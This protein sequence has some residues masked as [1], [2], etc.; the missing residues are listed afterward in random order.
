MADIN[1]EEDDDEV[2]TARVYLENHGVA[3]LVDD[4]LADL[5]RVKPPSARMWLASYFAGEP[6]C[7]T[8]LGRLAALEK[9]VRTLEE[10][11]RSLRNGK[12]EEPIYTSA[13]D[14]ISD[15]DPEARLHQ[16]TSLWLTPTARIFEE[17]VGMLENIKKPLV[18]DEKEKVAIDGR[19]CL[20]VIDMQNDFMPVGSMNPDGGRFVVPEGDQTASNIAALIKSFAKAGGRV[21]CT[22]DYHPFDHCSF[23]S[24]G[25][26]FAPHCVQGSVGSEFCKP[27][28]ESLKKL[29]ISKDKK[30]RNVDIAFKGFHEDIDSLGALPYSDAYMKER[31][32]MTDKEKAKREKV[33]PIQAWTGAYVLKCSNMEKWDDNPDPNAPPDILAF[34]HQNKEKYRLSEVVKEYRKV[35][36]CGVALDYGVLDTA[37]SASEAGGKIE[38]VSIILDATRP[39]YVP[40]FGT[41][42]TGFLQKPHLVTEQMNV[43]RRKKIRF[44]PTKAFLSPE[45]ISSLIKQ[46]SLMESTTT[47][48][49]GGVFPHSFGPFA[50][51]KARAV[52]GG[53]FLKSQPSEDKEGEYDLSNAKM[54]K[55]LSRFNV[56]LEGKLSA[57]SPI[58]HFGVERRRV[59][60]PEG[61]DSFCWAYPLDGAH[62][63][64]E[65]QA[66]VLQCLHEPNFSF[67]VFGGF[68]YLRG[69]EV[70]GTNA[71]SLGE[72]MS[73]DPPQ[74]WPPDLKKKLINQKRFREVT[75]PSLVKAG[76]HWFVWIKP[77]EIPC[78]DHG[79]FGYLFHLN[80]ED[81]GPDTDKD[82]WFPLKDPTLSAQV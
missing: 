48:E 18:E 42:G 43:K 57:T 30:N 81:D 80:L 52:R 53:I 10:V 62:H 8:L 13:P 77:K 20:L 39:A 28:A 6:G 71:L 70:V 78:Y 17:Y 27:I 69:T 12:T 3:Q 79:G 15:T 60:I 54:L 35:F 19:C 24:E 64:T 68:V 21:I 34:N 44:L 9:E 51:R 63:L 37:V 4:A 33:C 74:K 47:K 67:P 72:G 58:N 82:I 40:G 31:L 1:Y 22:R 23:V 5:I 38:E 7:D 56:H 11:N 61:A 73:F 2:Q 29:M 46:N 50:L 16:K 14:L 66:R 25:G 55:S 26:R 59:E 65:E 41:V 49:V 76:A 32:A 75:F 36:I 45:D